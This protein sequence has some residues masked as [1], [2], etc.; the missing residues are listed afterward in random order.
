MSSLV[1]SLLLALQPAATS[2]GGSAAPAASGGGSG[3]MIGQ[4]GMMVAIFAVMYFVMIRPQQK[5]QQAHQQM[6]KGLK[7]GDVVR[8]DGGI[9]GEIVSITDTEVKLL[10]ADKTVINILRARIQGPDQPAASKEGSDSKDAE[11]SG[12]ASTK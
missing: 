10:I 6:L 11:K 12:A 4:I 5:Q 3:G 1:F 2:S 8:T 7:K 9:R